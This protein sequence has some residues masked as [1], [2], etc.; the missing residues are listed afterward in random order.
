MHDT[1]VGTWLQWYIDERI[2]HGD[3]GIYMDMQDE[4]MIDIHMDMHDDLMM[5]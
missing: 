5:H 1:Y 4:L 3:V 2:M